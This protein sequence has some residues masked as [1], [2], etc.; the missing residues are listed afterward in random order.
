MSIKNNIRLIEEILA[1]I[2]HQHG[3]KNLRALRELGY[4]IGLMARIANNDNF[5]YGSLKS[6]LE[7]LQTKQRNNNGTGA[8]DRT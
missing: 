7:R 2:E 4:L 8:R 6:E 5:V 1:N 3:D